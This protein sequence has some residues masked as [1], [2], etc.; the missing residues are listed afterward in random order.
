MRLKQAGTA[1]DPE[2][3]IP[4][5]AKRRATIGVG[6]WR[7]TTCFD[8]LRRFLAMIAIADRAKKWRG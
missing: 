4:D 6:H 8:L 3:A 2:M 5:Q 1:F 7:A